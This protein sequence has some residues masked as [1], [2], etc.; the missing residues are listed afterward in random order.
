VRR[1]LVEEKAIRLQEE[2]VG[3]YTRHRTIA[4][5]DA[6]TT[7]FS[8]GELAIVDQV[9]ADLSGKTAR[10][11]S[12]DSHRVAWHI[13]GDREYIPYEVAFLS[14]DKPTDADIA[15]AQGLN[16]KYGWGLQV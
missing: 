2:P 8:K 6:D 16:D 9:I 13:L 10:K 12:D 15:D 7:L 11:I 1:D 14:D 3:N 5:R 4:L